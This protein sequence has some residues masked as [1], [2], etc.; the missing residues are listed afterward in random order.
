[1]CCL[2]VPQDGSL[3]SDTPLQY[4][5]FI[6]TTF[7]DPIYIFDINKTEVPDDTIDTLCPEIINLHVLAI[8]V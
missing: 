4:N 5:S 3:I 1:M 7:K 8:L 2:S 6:G